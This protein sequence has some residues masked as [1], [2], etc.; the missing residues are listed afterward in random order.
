MA[1]TRPSPKYVNLHIKKSRASKLRHSSS[2]Y[3][4]CLLLSNVPLCQSS[5]LCSS[6]LGYIYCAMADHWWSFFKI[7]EVN[8]LYIIQFDFCCYS[9]L[10]SLLFF[11]CILQCMGLCCMFC[12]ELR[13]LVEWE[14][15]PPPSKLLMTCFLFLMLCIYIE[16]KFKNPPQ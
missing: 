9:F 15:L 1:L 10:I 2:T 6:A 13:V 12:D 4:L 11:N 16:L 5:F 14:L 8:H 7:V 3:L